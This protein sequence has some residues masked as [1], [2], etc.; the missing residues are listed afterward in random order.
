MKKLFILLIPLFFICCGNDRD[1]D[2]LDR[3][4]SRDNI[5]KFERCDNSIILLYREHMPLVYD[6]PTIC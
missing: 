3:L 6:Y 4:G 5:K 1:E 2:V